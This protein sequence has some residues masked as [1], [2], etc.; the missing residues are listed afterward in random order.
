MS[1]KKKIFIHSKGSLPGF[2]VTFTTVKAI[3]RFLPARK[4]PSVFTKNLV[5][6]PN[7]P[8]GAFAGHLLTTI[9][10][11]KVN[12]KCGESFFFLLIT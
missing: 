12:V 2:T 1:Q 8:A 3:T 7:T 9:L 4:T 5:N 6:P 10:N 11:A